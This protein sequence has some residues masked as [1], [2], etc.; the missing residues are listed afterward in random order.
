[1]ALQIILGLA[2]IAMSGVVA[3]VV[4]F[5]LNARREERHFRRQRLEHLFGAFSG[6]CTQLEVD[7]LPYISVM[8]GKIDYN[9]ALDM[10]IAS[11]KNQERNLEDAEMLVAIY[12]PELQSDVDALKNVRDQADS[13]LREHKARYLAGCT[14]DKQSLDAIGEVVGRLRELRSRFAQTVRGE[15]AKLK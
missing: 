14:E 5:K 6:F 9:Q 4:T 15:A 2:T 3:G 10:T 13:V 8:K 11:G 1:M 12:W 7:W